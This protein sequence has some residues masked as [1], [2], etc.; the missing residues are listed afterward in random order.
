[1]NVDDSC[2]D[3]PANE[4]K[5]GQIDDGVDD[6]GCTYSQ[7]DADGDSILNSIDLCPGT[8]DLHQVDESGCSAS[9]LSGNSEGFSRS[10]LGGFTGGAILIVSASIGAGVL[11]KKRGRQRN[12][13]RRRRSNPNS[14]KVAESRS[15]TQS[16]EAQST[17][18]ANHDDSDH[19]VSVDEHG[20]EWY[21][22][23]EVWWYRTPEMVDWEIYES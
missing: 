21:S 10:V 7:L 20:T 2:P 16:V 18:T 15:A 23:D 1:M 17:S 5:K 11:L 13:K 6:D 8:P 9:Q 22:E 3:T 19:G 14:E 12:R 4:V